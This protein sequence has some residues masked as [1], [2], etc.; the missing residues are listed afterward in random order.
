MQRNFAALSPREVLQVA[1]S[2]ENRNAELYHHFAELFTEFGDKESLE[3]AAIFWEMA[4]EERGHSSQLKQ[5]YA[6][7]YGEFIS[8]ISEQDLVEIVEVP[9]LDDG[10]L[11]DPSGDPTPAR[12][13]ALQVALQAELSAQQFYEK[14]ASQTSRGP[15][16]DIFRYLAQQED[17][18]VAYLETKL[19]Q[20]R[21]DEQIVQ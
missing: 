9:T 6:E 12:A 2:I 18:H 7:L 20:S 21:T 14:L 13:R 15:L 8:S 16:R 19:E 1:I 17:G 5:H 11:L 10:N 3:I 4:V